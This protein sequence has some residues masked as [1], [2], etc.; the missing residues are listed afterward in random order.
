[1][2]TPYIFAANIQFSDAAAYAYFVRYPD[3]AA[4]YRA[5]SFGMTPDAYA[6]AHYERF[7]V[8]ERRVWSAALPVGGGA[9]SGSVPSGETAAAAGGSALPLILAAA[10]AYFLG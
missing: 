4:A 6:R 7:G 8:P 5:N 2:A 3:V 10:A 9:G 1:M